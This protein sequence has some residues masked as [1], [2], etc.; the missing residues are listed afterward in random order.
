MLSAEHMAVNTLYLLSLPCRSGCSCYSDTSSL[1]DQ[2]Y[3]SLTAVYIS[4]KALQL[5]LD[6]TPRCSRL[7]RHVL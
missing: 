5:D 4:L 6:S 1:T 3:V 2:C 7:W